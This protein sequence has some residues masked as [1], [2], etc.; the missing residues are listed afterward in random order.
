MSDGP[1]TWTVVGIVLSTAG[2]GVSIWAVVT[3]KNVKKTVVRMV[4]RA[5]AQTDADTLKSAI[6]TVSAAKKAAKCRQSNAPP[7]MAR[8]RKL[9]DDI[10]LLIDAEDALRTR[11]PPAIPP[12]LNAITGS[13][14]DDI[15]L[16]V[17]EMNQRN[18]Q[19]DG[20]AD[21][22]GA[23]SVVIPEM[24]REYRRLRSQT[25]ALN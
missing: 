11:L 18:P 2:L 8:G 23:L 20:W 19:R 13:A 6:D 10:G 7:S 4:R 14:A 16:A 22:L 12:T 5:N 21:A 15:R 9:A 3:A 1:S 17:N 25:L 24:E